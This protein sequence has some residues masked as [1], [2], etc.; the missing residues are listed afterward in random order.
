[1]ILNRFF[2]PKS[3]QNDPRSRLQALQK[4]ASGDPGLVEYAQRDE[5]PT[6]RRAAVNKLTSLPLLLQVA[7]ADSSPEVRDTANN[8]YRDLLAGAEPQKS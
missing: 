7:T 8:R 6:I 1:M 2:R 5:D 3:Q 4:L